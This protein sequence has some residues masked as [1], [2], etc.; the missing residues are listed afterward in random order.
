MGEV[1]R[2][3]KAA[4]QFGA[5]HQSNRPPWPPVELHHVS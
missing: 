3:Q 4:L 1:G 2:R 5:G